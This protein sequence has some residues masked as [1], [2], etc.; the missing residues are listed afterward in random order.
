VRLLRLNE[1]PIA[2]APEVTAGPGRQ[3]EA[4]CGRSM[5]REG[6]ALKRAGRGPEGATGSGGTGDGR[7][8]RGPRAWRSPTQRHSIRT[9][10]AIE[11]LRSLET[12]HRHCEQSAAGHRGRQV[13]GAG[14]RSGLLAVR[15]QLMRQRGAA[16]GAVR[17]RRTLRQV[18][19][20]ARRELRCA[21]VMAVRVMPGRVRVTA[22]LGR[23]RVHGGRCD[24]GRAGRR[25]RAHA[26]ADRESGERERK[27][28]RLNALQAWDSSLGRT[29]DRVRKHRAHDTPHIVAFNRSFPNDDNHLPPNESEDQ[30]SVN[31]PGMRSA[32]TITAAFRG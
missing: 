6:G 17:R 12:L 14:A 27:S 29:R 8:R 20:V 31:S 28:D 19:D 18:I 23:R 5:G 13:A 10:G 9:R 2:R 24:R 16:L 25:G 32:A 7:V 22:V 1:G 4:A 30:G 3:H 21:R 15:A 11:V 26:R